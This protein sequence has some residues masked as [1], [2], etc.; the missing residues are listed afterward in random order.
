MAIKANRGKYESSLLI[1]AAFAFL[2]VLAIFYFDEGKRSFEGF[3][4]PGNLIALFFYLTLL[5]APAVGIYSLLERKIIYW[6]SIPIS[7]ILG[8]P[9]LIGVYLGYGNLF[10]LIFE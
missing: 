1:M 7:M 5:Y 9:L 10:R 6:I 3:F 4:Y 2:I 8:F